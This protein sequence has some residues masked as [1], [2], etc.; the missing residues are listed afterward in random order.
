MSNL[1]PQTLA[2]KKKMQIEII[3]K[4]SDAK[5][6]ER[7]KLLLEVEIRALKSKIQ[8]TEMEITSKE[9]K[10]KHIQDQNMML[11]NELIKLKHQMNSLH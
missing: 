5:K 11:Q 1:D 6:Y 4:E 8:Q 10:L 9:G 3:L 7:E 2:Q